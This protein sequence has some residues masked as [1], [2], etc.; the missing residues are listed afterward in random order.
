VSRSAP[1]MVLGTRPPVASFPWT[2]CPVCLGPTH[3]RGLLQR[4]TW[5]AR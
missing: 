4:C 1:H 5:L 3:E 2:G